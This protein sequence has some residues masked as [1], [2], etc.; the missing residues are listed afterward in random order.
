MFTNVLCRCDVCAFLSFD[1]VAAL[2]EACTVFSRPEGDSLRQEAVMAKLEEVGIDT[3]LSFDVK[4]FRE[5]AAELARFRQTDEFA[6]HLNLSTGYLSKH[7]DSQY[8]EELCHLAENVLRVNLPHLCAPFQKPGECANVLG[9]VQNCCGKLL[10]VDG[11]DGT[12]PTGFSE[13]MTKDLGILAKMAG[14]G[15]TP[16]KERVRLQRILESMRE[17]TEYDGVLSTLLHADVWPHV[18][19]AVSNEESI[20]Q[21]PKFYHR[22]YH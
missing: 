17:D 16:H 12:T 8:K 5:K 14:L 15:D 10:S 11:P 4:F 22:L 3:P 21:D 18:I 2:M 19:A 9:H 6:S 13:Q 20:A 7:M 1:E